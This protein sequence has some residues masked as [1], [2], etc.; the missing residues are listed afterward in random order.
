MA[1]PSPFRD[2]FAALVH[3][4]LL[5]AAE[6]TW[7]WCFGLAAWILGIASMGMFLDSLT[8]SPV[9]AFV[10]RTFQPQFVDGALR[11]I[12]RGS[13]TRFLLMQAVLIAGVTLLWSLAATV[14]RAATL[15]RLVA[16]FSS[17]DEP[18]SL[19][20]RFAPIFVLQL[21]RAMWS[22]IALAVAAAMFVYGVALAEGQHPLRG[23]FLLSAGSGFALF[24]GAVLNW[25][26]GVAPIFCVRDRASAMEAV[27]QTVDFAG[28]H[29]G[30]LFLLAAGFFVLRLGWAGMMCLAFLSP[31]NFVSGIGAGWVMCLMTGV[32]LVYFSGADTLY[33]ARLAAYV[34]LSHDEGYTPMSEPAIPAEILPLEGLA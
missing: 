34:A 22:L 25:F 21:L 12:F 33:L 15:R 23:A 29:A 4:P 5:P 30:R 27:M 11:H 18:Q 8:V 6:L 24:A 20:W 13:L 1:A 32:A 31:L 10:L 19:E 16:M 9:D 7:R 14:G 28:R 26:L 2:G 17:D 3:E